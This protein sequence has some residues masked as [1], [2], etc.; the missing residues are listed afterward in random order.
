M[1]LPAFHTNIWYDESYTVAMVTHTFSEIWEIGAKD[2]HPVLYYY[3]IKIVSLI[4]GSN[5]LIYRLFSV[6]P[7]VIILILGYTHIRKDFGEKTGILFSFIMAVFPVMARYAVEIRMYSWAMLFVTITA[8]Y[9]YRLY[10]D[11]FTIK[12]LIIFGIFSLAGAYTHYYGLMASGIIN[13][14]IF[15]YLIK[16]VKLKKKETV[17]FTI[18]AVLQVLLYIP[19]L[20]IFLSQVDSVATNGFW[21]TLSFPYTLIDVISLQLASPHVN[22]YVAFTIMICIF[23][24]IFYLI[25]RTRKEKVDIKPGIL[26]ISVYLAVTLSALILSIL[27]V[28]ILQDRYLLV[29][30]G[31]L[32]FFIAF[33][34]SK[35]R[36][37]YITIAICIILLI[38]SAYNMVQTMLVNYSDDNAEML[39]YVADNLEDEDSFLIYNDEIAGFAISVRYLEHNQYF[40]DT[41]NWG[42]GGAYNS[43]GPNLVRDSN[44][45]NIIEQSSGR[46]WIINISEE[47]LENKI[48]NIYDNVKVIERKEFLTKYNGYYFTFTII[49][50]K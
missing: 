38:I 10:K 12:N 9:G 11:R 36:N 40:H 48:L 50:K 13:L 35:E 27:V 31:L 2:V 21:I 34:M 16:N 41:N 25:Y 23:I 45:N 18:C 6:L 5:I 47:D 37:K 42:A 17:Q 46:I 22:K 3:I 43:F 39:K 26:S 7:M 32:G 1:L 24:Y 30:T 19:W 15:A 4:F 44:L 28:P 33:F 20:L 14:I 49:E 29:V 8:I